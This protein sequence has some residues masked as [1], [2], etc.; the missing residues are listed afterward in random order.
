[1]IPICM[2]NGNGAGRR[3]WRIKL[4]FLC[5][6]A[7]A[8]CYLSERYDVFRVRG[9]D[10]VP[11]GIL[12]GSVIWDALPDSVERF[13]PSMIF[14]SRDFIRAIESFYPVRMSVALSGWGEIRVD[15]E[16]LRVFAFVSWNSRK[17]ML[18]EDGRMWLANLPAN[19]VVKGIDYPDSPILAWD[20]S[21]PIPIDPERQ[22]GDIYAASLNIDNIKNWYSTIDKTSWRGK[23]YC[24]MAK[25]IEGRPSVQA[26]FGSEGSITTEII[27]RDDAKNW[28]DLATAMR[29]IF[30]EDEYMH[31]PGKIINAN[32]SD[33][34]FTVTDKG[35]NVGSR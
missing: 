3:R 6:I 11:G 9:I 20:A 24:L 35:K 34:K 14:G 32:F 2:R 25:K 17:W 7:G 5:F 16:P 4:I 18:S 1:M 33:M 26:L 12:T 29:K 23:I 15:I 21:M 10:V 13:W 22:G 19:A 27:L 31:A 30:P 8:L 28:E